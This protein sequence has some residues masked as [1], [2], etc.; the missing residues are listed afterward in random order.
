MVNACPNCGKEVPAGNFSHPGP[1]QEGLSY[2]SFS[3]GFCDYSGL[4]LSVEADELKKMKFRPKKIVHKRNH[5]VTAALLFIVGVILA[6]ALSPFLGVLAGIILMA[7]FGILVLFWYDRVK[8]AS[9]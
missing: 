6:T 2:R 8:F 7:I 1:Y 5:K 3:C 9:A 4:P